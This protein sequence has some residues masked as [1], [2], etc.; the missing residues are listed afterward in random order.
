MIA[1]LEEPIR[2]ISAGL[3]SLP[4]DLPG[5][6]FNRAIRASKQIKKEIESMVVQRKIDLMNLN[7]ID[8]RAPQDLMSTLL[9]ERYSDGEE[10]TEADIANKLC[11]LLLGAYDTIIVTLCSIIMFLSQIPQVY[12]AVLKGTNP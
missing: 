5:T 3:V 10:M 1:K 2:H 8:P 6:N 7:L 11:G 9:M 12:D 4:V